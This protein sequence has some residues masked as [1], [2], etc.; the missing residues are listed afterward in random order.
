MAPFLSRLGVGGSGGFGFSGRKGL[1][2]LPDL[3]VPASINVPGTWDF[4]T[5]GNLVLTTPGT[6]NITVNRTLSKTVK[7]WGAGGGGIDTGPGYGAGGGGGS[8]TGTVS[9]TAGPYVFVV[10]SR[11]VTQN[12]TNG[13][14]GVGGSIPGYGPGGTAS[15]PGTIATYYSGTG[16][17]GT[18]LHNGVSIIMVA[19]AGGGGAFQGAGGAGGG[20]TGANGGGANP[21]GGGTQIAVGAGGLSAS[22]QPE[23]VVAAEPG[24]TQTVPGGSGGGKAASNQPYIIVGGGGGGYYGG[25]GGGTSYGV[26]HSGGGGGSGYINP[27]FVTS[28]TLYSG[29]GATAGNNTDPLYSPSYAFGG[30]PNVT[31]GPLTVGGNGAIIVVA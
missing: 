5:N 18:G 12:Q 23:P 13:P 21:G 8:S 9:F 1:A 27:S 20:T 15:N 4:A 31:P 7:M 3:T 2:N 25:G 10:G 29:S 19:G 28:G 17:G 26:S 14:N 24:G 16:G 6:Y 11:G 30:S 22:P